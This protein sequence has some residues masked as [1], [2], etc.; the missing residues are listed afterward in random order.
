MLA[1]GVLAFLIVA[2]IVHSRVGRALVALRENETLARAVGIR[3]TH[4]LVL[5]TV[6]SAAI[7]GAAGS[8]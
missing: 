4:Y 2:G 7:A 8:L 6:I 5:A 3:A 1:V